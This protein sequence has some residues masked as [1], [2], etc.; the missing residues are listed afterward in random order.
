M[1]K[2]K[3]E[4]SSYSTPS[5]CSR[6][7]TLSLKVIA[8]IKLEPLRENR[9]R[10]VIVLYLSLL[11]R[12]LLEILNQFV[13]CTI[14]TR[15]LLELTYRDTVPAIAQEYFTRAIAETFERELLLPCS[16]VDTHSLQFSTARHGRQARIWL[17][18]FSDSICSIEA[19]YI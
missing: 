10:L 14:N 8:V 12:T 4:S 19:A 7:R 6:L 1:S 17:S 15:M 11:T 3:S 16:A 9:I 5:M 2:G 18:K 13:R